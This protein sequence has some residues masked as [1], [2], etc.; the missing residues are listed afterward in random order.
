MGAALTVIILGTDY[1]TSRITTWLNPWDDPLDKGMQAIQSLMAIGS[2]G[3]TGLGLATGGK[4]FVL[5]EARTTYF[6]GGL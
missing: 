3:V 5:P 2:G 6:R 1:M 4:V